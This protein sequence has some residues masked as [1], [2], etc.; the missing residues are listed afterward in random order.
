[1]AR[2]T[3]VPRLDP[4]EKEEAHEMTSPGARIIHEVIREEGQEEL[5]RTSSA[6]AWS[7][8]MAGVT[9]GFS[10]IAE[11][12]LRHHL[13][14]DAAWTPLIAKLGLT[15]GFLLVI[16][17]R[18]QLF[19]ENTLLPIIPLLVTRRAR[20]LRNV[21]RLWSVV[22]AANLVGAWVVAWVLAKSALFADPVKASF[23][24]VGRESLAGSFGAHLLKGVFAGWLIA[25]AV[26]IM[27]GARDRGAHIIFLLTYVI[28][29]AG[30]NHVISGS[31]DV[32]F[33]VEAG[34][35]AWRDYLLAFL[36]P[37]LLGNVIGGLAMV[38]IANHA[39]VVAGGGR[40]E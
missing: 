36:P 28:G 35:S 32:M 31:I 17:A 19:T 6:L 13:P 22:L 14:P 9:M 25:L 34:Q 24:Q 21:S 30:F 23:A 2:P 8:A 10:L 12:L 26:W 5:A 1:M 40:R 4:K 18:Q 11:G 20:D 27:G 33:L 29:I 37:V 38:A 15:V 39:Q 7:G 16:L 3:R